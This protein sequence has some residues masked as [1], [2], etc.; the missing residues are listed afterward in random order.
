MSVLTSQSYRQKKKAKDLLDMFNMNLISANYI[1]IEVLW[2]KYGL[3]VSFSKMFLHRL[4]LVYRS[5]IL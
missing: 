2:T 5:S 4:N 3:P 1:N